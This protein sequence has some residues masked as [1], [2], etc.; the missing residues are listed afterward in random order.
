MADGASLAVSWRPPTG[1][2]DASVHFGIGSPPFTPADA[3]A[4]I[5]AGIAAGKRKPRQLAT[6]GA[7]A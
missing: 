7:A 5:R 2:A 3:R 4:T 1:R 6:L